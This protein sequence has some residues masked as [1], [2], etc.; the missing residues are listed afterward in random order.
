MKGERE[1][2]KCEMIR[3]FVLEGGSFLMIGGYMSFSGIIAVSRYHDTAI[4]DILPVGVLKTDDQVEIPNGI[5]PAVKQPDHPIFKGIP[6][7][8]SWPYFLEYNRT[9]FSEGVNSQLL[10]EIG[11]DPFIAVAEPE[12]GRSALFSSD[13]APHWGSPAF[14]A[15]EHYTRL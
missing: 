3:D 1:P 6:Q 2:D 10:A 15:W 8:E 7:D 11:S 5:L 9:G 14:L 12:K 13:R 4:A